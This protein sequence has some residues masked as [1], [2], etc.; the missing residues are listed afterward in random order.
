MNRI[1]L[2]LLM[3]CG[4]FSCVSPSPEQHSETKD[5]TVLDEAPAAEADVPHFKTLDTALSFAGL[6]VNETFIDNI[7]RTRSPHRSEG[8]MVEESCITIPART[9]QVTRMVAGFHEGAADMVVVKDK[10]RYKMYDAALE[11]VQKE[12]EIISPERIRIG[13]QYFGRI[14]GYDT[15]L[16]DLGIL[17][18]L[19]FQGR[20]ESSD[21]KEV[22]FAVDGRVQGLGEFKRYAPA[23]DLSA[24]PAGDFDHVELETVTGKRVDHGFRFAGDTLVIFQVKCFK[25][26]AS[27]SE[28]DSVAPGNILY[29][30]LR[31]KE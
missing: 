13:N 15:T 25:E 26:D 16:E 17:E 10:D 19:L 1:V 4:I 28:C 23:I 12:I 22:I 30:L 8:A 5:S 24:W 2:L 21:K 20:Y 14:T 7:R 11:N 18:E 29:R 3:A 27:S 31:K 6:W 9:L